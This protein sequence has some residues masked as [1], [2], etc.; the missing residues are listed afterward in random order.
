MSIVKNQIDRNE[1]WELLEYIP[2]HDRDT[3][4]KVGMALKSEFCDGGFALY[5]EWSKGADNYNS[6]AVIHAWRS[7]K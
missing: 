7:F 3:W 6:N 5:D 1:V 4:I 2:A